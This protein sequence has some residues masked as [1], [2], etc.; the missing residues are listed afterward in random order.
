MDKSLLDILEEERDYILEIEELRRR[1][2]KA[3]EK[4]SRLYDLW[5]HGDDTLIPLIERS[6][7]ELSAIKE[8]LVEYEQQLNGIR[9]EIKKK[10]YSLTD[11]T[12]ESQLD[13]FMNRY[14]K[15]G[16]ITRKGRVSYIKINRT[17]D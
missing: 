1:I 16:G 12:V 11:T 7:I 13:R 17:R 6:D 3:D 8:M 5:I 9:D 2:T 14:V 4:N 10:I 15:R